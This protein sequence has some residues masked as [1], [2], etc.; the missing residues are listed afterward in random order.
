MLL[1]CV[2]LA[3]A[4]ADGVR[5]PSEYATKRIQ[6]ACVEQSHRR[7]GIALSSF[8]GREQTKANVLVVDGLVTL[9]GHGL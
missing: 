2:A 6:P 3:N 1:K 5:R 9:T 4:G 8:L 7:S